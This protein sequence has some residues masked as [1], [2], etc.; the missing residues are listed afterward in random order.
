MVLLPDGTV[1]SVGGNGGMSAHLFH[2][3]V[4]LDP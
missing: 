1:L 3:G 2:P 4:E